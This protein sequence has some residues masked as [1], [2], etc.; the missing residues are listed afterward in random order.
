M[1]PY[2]NMRGR[3][4][5]TPH[6]NTALHYFSGSRSEA[7][8]IDGDSHSASLMEHHCAIFTQV[9]ADFATHRFC[10]LTHAAQAARARH[11]SLFCLL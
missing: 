6:S 4:A 8:P 11:Y 9:M 10:N 7:C 1:L 5:T 3:V 2:S